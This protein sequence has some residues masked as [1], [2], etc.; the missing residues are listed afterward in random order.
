[1]MGMALLIGAAVVGGVAYARRARPAD[2]PPGESPLEILN[3]RY[4][5]GE[6]STDEY[7]TL[8]EHLT[9]GTQLTSAL[10]TAPGPATGATVR[11][12]H[13]PPVGHLPAAAGESADATSRLQPVRGE[14]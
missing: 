4:A 5:R 14:C 11:L 3:A 9:S 8:R 1:M 7:Y 6:V 2:Q 10:T 13:A 12:D